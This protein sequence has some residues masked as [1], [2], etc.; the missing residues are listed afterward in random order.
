MGFLL[1][2]EA[3]IVREPQT[4]KRARKSLKRISSNLVVQRVSETQAPSKPH[5]SVR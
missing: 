4:H 1:S 2:V 3:G 5:R